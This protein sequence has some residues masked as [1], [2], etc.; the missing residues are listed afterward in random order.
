MAD[1]YT[2]AI[3]LKD[4]LNSNIDVYNVC[5]VTAFEYVNNDFNRAPWAGLY[6]PKI[7]FVSRTLGT[8]N[9]EQIFTIKIIIQAKSM[10]SGDECTQRLDDHLAKIINA[11]NTDKTINN[12]VEMLNSIDVEYGYIETERTSLFFQ[13]AIITLEYEVATT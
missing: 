8:N 5:P 9:W 1:M 4:L 3:G 13:S 2:V 11:V 7:K 10:N 6:K 12:N